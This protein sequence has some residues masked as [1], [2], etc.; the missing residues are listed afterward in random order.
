MTTSG[1][2]LGRDCEDASDDRLIVVGRIL[3][4]Y[5]IRGWVK[6][7]SETDP[8]ANIVAYSPW[9]VR[10]D[11][12]WERRELAAG[13]A[14]AKGVIARLVG[15]DDRDTAM[16]LIGAQ[17]AVR[18]SQLADDLAPDQYYWADLEGLRVVTL[19][20]IPLGRVDHL[21]ATG[22]NDV[23]VVAGERDRLIP[24]LVDKV[25]KRVGLETGEMRVDWDPEF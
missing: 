21:L 5:G 18:R 11:Q 12:G 20:G 19:D 4:P 24:Y 25:V 10:R 7:Q 8:R 22:A 9:W 15:C 23:L 16:A 1:G 14:H 17:I 2:Q 6:V 13:R 3:G